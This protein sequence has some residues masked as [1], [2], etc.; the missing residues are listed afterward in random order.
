MVLR[1]PV[2]GLPLTRQERAL[3]CVNGH[4]F[5]IARQGYSNLLLSD[6][7]HSHD[8]GDTKEQVLARRAF[9]EGE[10]YAPIC[11]SLIAS[12]R[13]FQLSGAL[14][15]VG[16]GEGYY[17]AR[18][19]DAMQLELTGMDISREAVRWAA[20][21]YK[22]PV[23]LCAS[24][25]HIPVMDA[26]A[27]ILT[28]LFSVTIPE[29]FHRVLKPGGMFFQVLA[30]EDHLMGLKHIIYDEVFLKE[31]NL[32]PDLPGFRL[33][34][35]RPIRFSF[36]VEGAAVQQLLSMTPHVYRIGK[37]GVERLRATERLTD[38]ASCVLNC[39]QAVEA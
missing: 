14:L 25:A 30:G 31:K 10:Y 24:A 32:T 36:T 23:W 20:A 3:R 29:E 35:S 37:G 15:D 18:L 33:V 16:C 9:L 8:P 6:Q 13:E 21:K 26:Q 2:C 27:D 19:A 28:S 17:S 7:K 5:D 22:G 34:D 38:E 39:Y 12:A 4:S 11:R 1:C